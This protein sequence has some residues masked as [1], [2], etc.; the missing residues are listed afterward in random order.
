MTDRPEIKPLEWEEI[1]YNRSNEEPIPELTG[2]YAETEVGSYYVMLEGRIEVTLD[3]IQFHKVGSF[4]EPEAAFEAA[5]SDFASRIRSCLLDK[6]EAVEVEPV[7]W[8]FE[9]DLPESY[10][11]DIM[12]KFSKVDGVRLFPV[13]APS[14]AVSEGGEDE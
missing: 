11:Y 2:W 7:A 6:P 10:P 8:I 9:D 5:Q 4:D 13:Y 1:H 12:F 14:Q 3:G